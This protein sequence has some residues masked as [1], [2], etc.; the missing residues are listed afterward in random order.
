MKSAQP[1]RHPY[2]IQRIKALMRSGVLD[3]D[4]GPVLAEL[5][6]TV[7]DLC[8]A[9]SV[10]ACVVPEEG[11]VFLGEV[12]LNPVN[13]KVVEELCRVAINEEQMREANLSDDSAEKVLVLPFFD[14]QSR[15]PLGAIYVATAKDQAL[16]HDQRKGLEGFA[17]HVE[18]VLFFNQDTKASR[19]LMQ[20]F[21][22][23]TNRTWHILEGAE[24]GSWDWWLETNTVHFD[25]RWCQ[26]I[27]LQPTQFEHSYEAWAS[28]VHPEDLPKAVAKI[29]NHV[30]GRSDIYEIVYRMRHTS[31]EW[32]WILSRGKVSERNAAGRPTR[33]TGTH[34]DISSFKKTES[35]SEQIQ[36]MAK[37][38]GWEMDAETLQTVWT[39]QVYEIYGLPPGADLHNDEAVKNYA[40]HEQEKLLAL[41]KECLNGR[42]Y[43]ARLEFRDAQG[44]NKWVESTGA[45]IRNANGKITKLSGTFQDV[46]AQV[47]AEKSAASS[48]LKA[49]HTAKLASL[50]EMSAA[51]AHEI[52]NP[53]AIINGTVSLLERHI[54]N[55]QSFAEKVATI[56]RAVT[57]IA[58]IVAGLRRFSRSVDRVEMRL[59]NMNKIVTDAMPLMEIRSRRKFVNLVTDL[60]SKA[61]VKCDAIEIEQVIVNLV[62]N[63]VD[64][65]AGTD[66]ASVIIGTHDE[67][68]EVVLK[69]SDSGPGLAQAV[70]DRIFEPFVTSKPVGEGTGLGLSICKGILD[71]HNATIQFEPR[72][73]RTTVVVRI[74]ACDEGEIEKAA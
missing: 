71:N 28:R 59:E 5:A 51:I 32:V 10:G 3:Q 43:H 67:G 30:N 41:V 2:E 38:G 9:Q 24:L 72:T 1:Q 23:M 65:A 46:T 55:P 26:M 11:V 66:N 16:S 34:L 12:T 61:L 27:G 68:S 18:R 6:F 19:R 36:K 56:K 7:K 42:P 53:L 22:E 33:F 17:N 73:D 31:G 47:L 15:F 20:E 25:K 48:K 44:V 70:V 4:F 39:D 60:K 64:A 49:T 40:P 13:K 74:K 57:R 63:G 50:G 29:E 45:P 37:I 8:G 69:I 35:L 21:S 52:N 14:P 54:A 62:N 58:K